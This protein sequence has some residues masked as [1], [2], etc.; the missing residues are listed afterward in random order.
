MLRRIFLPDWVWYV[1]IASVILGSWL[2]DNLWFIL[3]LVI[4]LIIQGVY[5]FHFVRCPVCGGRVT[6]HQ[7]FIPNTTRYR[8]QL[9][10]ARCQ[11]IWDTGKI[12]DDS[13]L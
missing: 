4:L 13:T 7:C 5:V 2:T 6:F 1:L 3:G 8:F 10:C 9:A 11:I 12:S